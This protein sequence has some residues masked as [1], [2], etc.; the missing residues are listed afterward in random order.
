MMSLRMLSLDEG[1]FQVFAM[2]DIVEN[3]GWQRH[4][5]ELAVQRSSFNNQH[6]NYVG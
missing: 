1:H 2:V 6:F 4:G 3:F 5:S